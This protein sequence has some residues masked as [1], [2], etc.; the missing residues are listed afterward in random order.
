MI[1]LITEPRKLDHE[2]AERKVRQVPGPMSRQAFLA[3]LTKP[4]ARLRG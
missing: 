4:V 1:Y 2:Y 3:M